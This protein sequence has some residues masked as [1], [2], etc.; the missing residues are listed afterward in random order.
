MVKAMRAWLK[1]V[2]SLVLIISCVFSFVPVNTLRV[3]AETSEDKYFSAQSSVEDECEVLDSG[4]CGESLYWE[5]Y[6]NGQLRIYGEGPMYDY[7]KYYEPSPWYKYRDEPYISEDG[8][9]FLDTNGDT[10]VS[11][12]GYYEKNPN[13]YKVRSI[14]IEDGVTYIG[15]WAFYRVCV[16]EI[17]VPE[18]VEATGIFCFRYSPTL[19]RLNLPD[20]LK[21]LDDFAIS[22]NYVL[23]T[24]N[25]G[26]SLEKVGTAGFNNNPSLT[27]VILPD[28]CTSINK[29]LSPAY[30]NINYSSVGLMEN[31]SALKTVSFGS[32]TDIPQR[33]C[34]GTAIETVVIPNTVENIG[35]YAFYNCKK[36]KTVVFEKESVCK[37]ITS[38]S[39]SACTSLESITGGTALESLGS[40]TSLENLKEFEFSP[41]NKT[42]VKN[43]FFNTA[44]KKV[45]V[46]DNISVIPISCFNSMAYLEE[47]YLPDTITDILGSSFNYC[48]SLRDIYYEG[49]LSQWLAINK[50]DGWN[51]KVNS[52]C[53]LHLADGK[54]VS[55]WYK[56]TVYT[57]TFTDYDGTVLDVQK[58]AQGE[59]AVAPEAP[60]RENDEQYSYT[61]S[62]W[63]IAFDNITSDIT[64]VA[65]YEKSLLKGMLFIDT[66]GGSGFELSVAGS[67]PRPQGVIYY[68]C[69]FPADVEVTVKANPV[70]AK[71]FL[72]WT[73]VYSGDVLSNDLSFSFV[74]DGNN[75]I[76]AVYSE[77]EICANKVVLLSDADGKSAEFQYYATADEFE[78]PETA[79]MKENYIF[80]GWSMTKDEVRSQLAEDGFVIVSS[81]W[82]RKPVCVDVCKNGEL[83]S[84]VENADKYLNDC[85][86][87]ITAKASF[88]ED[89]AVY[90][91]AYWTNGEEILS[92]DVTYTFSS[93]E[94]E[95]VLAVFVEEGS[96]QAG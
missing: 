66:A 75:Y 19:K 67:K 15:D 11:T 23:E 26:N 12:A 93:H 1:I 32:V 60:F 79:P 77:D 21:V 45:T 30:A 81:D 55:L 73:D 57:V 83:V 47:I 6:S 69:D 27:Q 40:Y 10:Y 39:F 4:Q 41:T 74:T 63:D 37:N 25:I 36:L 17:T 96:M 86:V 16:E 48:S 80:T 92:Y 76:K 88:V 58:I 35:E 53:M 78:F 52:E 5:L 62:D 59:S 91:F 28:T 94:E 84:A 14:V 61:F 20:S 24:V 33:T 70:A 56:P 18:T 95:N 49:T 31:C 22:R 29:Q 38:T 64:V 2:L 82:K 51:Y 65:Q 72:G 85:T 7:N 89:G 42:L 71:E 50:A 90:I 68:D 46:S 87:T 54:S 3:S 43:Q 34:L 9:Y 44:L 8:A 13:G